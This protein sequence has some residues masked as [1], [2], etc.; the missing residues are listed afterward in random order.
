MEYELYHHGIL[1]M[2]W[3]IRR[4]QNKDG[5]LTDAGKKR[6]KT[7]SS[8]T[9]AV[10]KKS[11]SLKRLQDVAN[12]SNEYYTKVIHPA[13]EA[14]VVD[15]ESWRNPDSLYTQTARLRDQ[16]EDKF[17]KEYEDAEYDVHKELVAGSKK[18]NEQYKQSIDQL[19]SS[20]KELTD[21][22]DRI[23]SDNQK[24]SEYASEFAKVNWEKRKDDLSNYGIKSLDQYTSYIKNVLKGKEG[25]S[26]ETDEVL[27]YLADKNP[28]IK[29]KAQLVL[30]N[31]A[32]ANKIA[33][34]LTR[35]AIKTAS[36]NS[37]FDKMILK[38]SEH[39]LSYYAGKDYIENIS[40][41]PYSTVGYTISDAWYGY[42]PKKK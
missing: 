21:S 22:L 26:E 36:K 24:V 13:E 30:K 9:K 39:S 29:K 3:G 35:D 27:N 4:Y 15:A 42:T 10:L 34:K 12:Y 31:N 16:L 28:V 8:L 6:Y 33:E 1:G 5:S 41:I 23:I 18:Y 14:G 17:F 38:G 20:R 2:K 40:G 25:I 37:N 11:S 32:S 7:S 19:I